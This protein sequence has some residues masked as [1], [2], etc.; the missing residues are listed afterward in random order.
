L[1]I[2]AE[3]S[4]AVQKGITQPV[5]L[6]GAGPLVALYERAFRQRGIRRQKADDLA[7]A[8]G[9]FKLAQEHQNASA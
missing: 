3:I 9:L 1:L 4:A 5:V 7:A 8:H 2:G 6:V